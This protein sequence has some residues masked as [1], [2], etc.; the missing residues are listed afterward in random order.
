MYDSGDAVEYDDADAN[1]TTEVEEVH[2]GYSRN[3]VGGG[4]SSRGGDS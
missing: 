1:S 2:K 4:S 3:T